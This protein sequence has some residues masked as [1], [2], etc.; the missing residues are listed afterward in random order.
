[1]LYII[2]YEVTSSDGWKQ[3]MLDMNDVKGVTDLTGVVDESS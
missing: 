2:L 3:G 1:M